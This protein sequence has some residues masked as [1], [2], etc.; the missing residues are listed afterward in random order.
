M[1]KFI[2]LQVFCGNRDVK[3]RFSTVTLPSEAALAEFNAINTAPPSDAAKFALRLL[4]VFFTTD[5]LAR[6]NCTKAEGRKL[7]NPKILQAIKRN[8]RLYATIYVDYFDTWVSFFLQIK[9]I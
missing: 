2:G 1:Y 4:G 5:E 9:P 8:G 3:G 7:L 6:S